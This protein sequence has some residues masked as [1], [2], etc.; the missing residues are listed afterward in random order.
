MG[1]WSRTK[2]IVGHAVDLRFDRWADLEGIKRT[3]VYLWRQAKYLFTPQKSQ[4]T[5]TF[6]AATERLALSDQELSEQAL[7]YRSLF[8]LFLIITSLLILYASIIAICGNWMGGII[9]VALSTYSLA[10][11][12]QFHF[13]HFQITHKKLGCS[14][15]E[16]YQSLRLKGMVKK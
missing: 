9:S 7:R 15:Q 5:E 11:A 14:I 10:L 4:Y 6:E 16:W 1:F 13:W 12:F 2:K 3:S 8:I